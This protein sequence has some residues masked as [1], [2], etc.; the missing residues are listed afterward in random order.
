MNS[1]AENTTI[2]ISSG[3]GGYTSHPNKYIT[4]T[5]QCRSIFIK[6]EKNTSSL[7]KTFL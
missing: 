7:Q 1:N 3:I 5:I 4:G 6:K 2:K